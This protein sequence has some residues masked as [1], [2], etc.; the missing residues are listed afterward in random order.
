M[1]PLPL[2]LPVLTLPEPP[3]PGSSTHAPE[4]DVLP[5]GSSR[6]I[7]RLSHIEPVSPP[8]GTVPEEHVNSTKTPLGLLRWL[9]IMKRNKDPAMANPKR[10]SRKSHQSDPHPHSKSPMRVNAGPPRMAETRR[11]PVS[12][13]GT[14]R[15]YLMN[16]TR[17]PREWSLDRLQNTGF[18]VP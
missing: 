4:G 3:S 17:Y 2:P 9:P 13:L 10:V 6:D 11:E 15:A 5:S 8:Q 1:S 18:A 7:Q 12:V 16:L 14:P